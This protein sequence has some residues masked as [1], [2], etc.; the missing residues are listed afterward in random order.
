MVTL[1]DELKGLKKEKAKNKV[2]T[3]LEER[4]SELERNRPAMPKPKL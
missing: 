3:P 4:I 1:K 2:V